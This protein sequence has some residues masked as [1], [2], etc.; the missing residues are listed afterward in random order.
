MHPQFARLHSGKHETDR[1]KGGGKVHS[2]IFIPV[3]RGHRF[4]RSHMP[5]NRVVD[6]DIDSAE[7]FMRH[8]HHLFDC[9]WI[10]EVRR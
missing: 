9:G 10:P 6:E 8:R 3:V 2:E 7:R 4:D 1:V 5:H